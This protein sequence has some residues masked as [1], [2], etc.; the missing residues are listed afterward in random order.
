MPDDITTK[1]PQYEAVS[2]Q[3]ERC[4]DFR[5]GSDT[6]KKGSY[7][8]QPAGMLDSDFMFY[9]TRAQYVNAMGRTVQALT[10]A[11]LRSDPAV[12]FPE[13][14]RDHLDDITMADESFNMVVQHIA[15]EVLT[16]GRIGV[17]VD[18]ALEGGKRPYWTTI[19][20][21]RIIN[22]RTE[23]VGADPARLTL[24]VIEE[25]PRKETDNSY[26]HETETR[27]RELAL[28]DDVYQARIWAESGEDTKKYVAGDWIIPTRLGT[29]L[30]YIP[31]TFIGPDSI[32]PSVSKPPL[33]DLVDVLAGH[34]FN[35]ADEEHSL[36]Y[37]S[38][39]TPWVSG[40][41]GD[42]P[43]KIGS[44]VAWELP[45][46]GRAGMLEHSGEGIGAIRQAMAAKEQRMAALGARLLEYPRS[47]TDETATAVRVRHSGDEAAL[48][49]IGSAMSAGLTQILRRHAWWSG[50]GEMPT[51]VSVEISDKFLNVTAT[52]DEVKALLLLLQSDSIDYPT[53]YERLQQGGWA[54]EGVTAD[55]ELAGIRASG[56]GLPQPLL[57]NNGAGEGDE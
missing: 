37:V 24:V 53:F 17:L 6:V 57:P 49:F 7:L 45:E 16:V 54:R 12:E 41:T 51:D 8:P 55:E 29:P 2:K 33:V 10:G 30:D 50:T 27:Y 46:G 43:L 14:L 1:H 39:P 52:P 25:A 22:W 40:T 48:S 23:K 19:S 9:K 31:F 35:S 3:W 4:R 36:F 5:A 26:A 11:L 38:Q 21:E 56:G 13:R 32:T 28:E 15:A 44:S 47:S 34:F 20:A 18:M 42:S